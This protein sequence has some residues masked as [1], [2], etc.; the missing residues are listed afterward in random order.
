MKEDKKQ[1]L[2]DVVVGRYGNGEISIG[3]NKSTLLIACS[4]TINNPLLKLFL[5]MVYILS[6]P[7]TIICAIAYFI[8]NG[9]FLYI[10]YYVVGIFLLVT[11][12][13][14]LLKRVAIGSALKS[15]R[16]FVEL[17][18]RGAIKIRDIFDPYIEP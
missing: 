15:E 13:D 14:K 1:S 18:K 6:H 10:L 8:F 2:H 12:E 17:Y 4:K 11:A 3:V 9:T 16:Y 7:L 5:L